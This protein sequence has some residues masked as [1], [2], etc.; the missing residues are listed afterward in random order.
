MHGAIFSGIDVRDYKMVCAVKEYD[1]PAEF[2]LKPVRVKNQGDVGSCVA[3]ALSSII[4]YYNSVQRNDPTEMSIGYIYGNRSNSEHKDS[5]MIMRDALDVVREFGDVPKE[6]FPQNA[7]TPA[8]LMLYRRKAKELYDVGRPNRI[9][10]YCRINTVSAAKLALSAGVPLLMAMEW[11]AD[12]KLVD[13]VLTTNYV[14]YEGG[15]CMFIYGWDERGWKIQ[16][17]WGEDWGNNGTFILPYELGMAEC[18]A[19]MDDII[20]GAYVKKPFQ[21][22]VG[23][24]FAKVVNKICNIFHNPN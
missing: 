14:G 19:V 7:E 24:T 9:S 18:W 10:E 2:E 23:K 5:G 17:S 4:E 3:H 6:C 22:K 8:A 20:E 21:S 16:N 12:M 1:F 13:G 15:H 11:Y